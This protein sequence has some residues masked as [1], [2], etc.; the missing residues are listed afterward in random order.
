MVVDAY[1]QVITLMVYLWFLL[2]TVAEQIVLWPVFHN[3]YNNYINDQDISENN[4]SWDL[5]LFHFSTSSST[6]LENKQY[7]SLDFL[8]TMLFWAGGMLEKEGQRTEC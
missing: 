7:I 6:I 4:F 3:L 5:I 8:N 2:S 1:L